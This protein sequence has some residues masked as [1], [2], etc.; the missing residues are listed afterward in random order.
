M[1]KRRALLFT[2]GGSLILGVFLMQTGFLP[3][4]AEFEEEQKLSVTDCAGTEKGQLNVAV[5][6]TFSE[7]YVGLSRTD[8]LAENEGL[9][10]AYDEAGEKEIAMRN[11]DFGLDIMFVSGDGE[12]TSI[13]TLDAPESVLSYYLLYDQTAGTGQF[14]IETSA[15]WSEARGVSAGDCVG[16]LSA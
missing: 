16:G 2:I 1:D 5:A 4:F 13:E 6:E 14:V 8:S 7:R 12:I 9:V 3:V 10:L 11:M 15:G